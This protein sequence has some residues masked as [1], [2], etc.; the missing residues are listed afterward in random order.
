M[1]TAE[2]EMPPALKAIRRADVELRSGYA[3]D[4][5]GARGEPPEAVFR[6]QNI[7][8]LRELVGYARRSGLRLQPISSTGSHGRGDTLCAARSA[9]VEMSS[10]DEVVRC[11]RRNRVLMFEAG[12]AFDALSRSAGAHGLR[13]MLP[14]CPRPGK[15]ALTS[16]L[17]REPT[18]YPRF[19]WDIADPLLCTEIVLGTGELFRTGAAA[20]PGTLVE[21]WLAGDAQTNPMGPGPADFMRIFQGAQGAYGIVTWCTSKAE[22]LPSAETLYVV[23]SETLEP[24]IELTY[25]LL[26]RGHPDICFLVDSRALGA[27]GERD[28]A[29]FERSRTVERPWNLVFSISKPRFAG[30]EKLAWVC[31]EVSEM[32]GSLGLGSDLPTFAQGREEMHRVLTDPSHPSNTRWWKLAD[33]DAVQE[34]FL[35]STLDRVPALLEVAERVLEDGG[36]DRS[37]VLRY[38]QPQLG[39]RCCH[40][41]LVLPTDAP[42]D[43]S[44]LVVRLTRELRAAGGYFSR[45]HGPG[46]DAAVEGLSALPLLRKL[47]RIFDPDSV[48]LPNAP[49]FLSQSHG[50]GDASTAG[51]GV[52]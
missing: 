18:I 36:L 43:V 52:S 4:D 23:G 26:R 38:V 27:L 42:Q 51:G 48:F 12:V 17:D 19:Q 37:E 29:S 16:Y 1:D 3:Q 50:P 49:G 45:P 13:A 39:G 14:L 7:G 15:S 9:V 6:P 2:I 5:S 22:P 34:L 25:R 47:G 46:L 35:Q 41:E 30:K 40:L 44:A 10:F 11:D 28:R 33:R 8:E 32:A 24:L 21:Q 31:R 20:G